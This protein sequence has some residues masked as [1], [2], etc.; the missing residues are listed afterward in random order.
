MKKLFLILIPVVFLFTGCHDSNYV[1]IYRGRDQIDE[2]EPLNLTDEN[3]DFIAKTAVEQNK[4]M[5][6]HFDRIVVGIDLNGK[7]YVY[8]ILTIEDMRRFSS[9][10]NSY[11]TN[12][13]W[14]EEMRLENPQ[15]E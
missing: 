9:A 6:K 12:K 1:T 15:D 11:R 13:L 14:T 5:M 8:T 10:Y 4:R 7:H 2:I 3:I